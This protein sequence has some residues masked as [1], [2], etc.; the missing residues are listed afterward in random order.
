MVTDLDKWFE[1]VRH[2]AC[3][4][5]NERQLY[6]FGIT[7]VIPQ[8]TDYKIG[9]VVP[10]CGMFVIAT[11]LGQDHNIVTRALVGMFALGVFVYVVMIAEQERHG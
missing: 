11:N 7:V 1:G 10:E 2:D 3:G 8:L 4:Q 9:M 5:R 6:G